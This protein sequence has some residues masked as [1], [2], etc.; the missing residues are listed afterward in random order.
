MDKYVHIQSKHTFAVYIFSTNHLSTSV[1]NL[2]IGIVTHVVEW[3]LGLPSLKLTYAWWKKSGKPIYIHWYAKY[4]SIYKVFYTSQVVDISPDF[5]TINSGSN[6]NHCGWRSWISALIFF[7]PQKRLAPRVFSALA[8]LQ[9]KIQVAHLVFFTTSFTSFKDAF[10]TSNTKISGL[11]LISWGAPKVAP[12]KTTI[13]NLKFWKSSRLGR[14]RILAPSIRG[15]SKGYIF[16]IAT[17]WRKSITWINGWVDGASI[18]A[19]GMKLNWNNNKPVIWFCKVS[20]LSYQQKLV[21]TVFRLGNIHTG[22]AGSFR[23]IFG[24]FSQ[25]I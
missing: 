1:S 12:T 16:Y 21:D 23:T 13:K 6:L 20:D 8:K 22:L 15:V 10:T 5:W 18:P 2:F 19:M 14:F 17:F 7:C 9:V 4:P 11:E 25:V 24:G 3:N